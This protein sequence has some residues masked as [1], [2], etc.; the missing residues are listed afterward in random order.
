VQNFRKNDHR[1]SV[2]LHSG[3]MARDRLT[4]RRPVPEEALTSPFA[5]GVAHRFTSLR[6]FTDELAIDPLPSFRRQLPQGQC[7]I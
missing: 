7:V 1:A 6:A 2:A 4:V 5:P 3:V